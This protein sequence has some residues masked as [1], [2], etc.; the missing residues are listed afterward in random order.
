[1]SLEGAS[2]LLRDTVWTTLVLSA[3]ILV[4]ALATGLLVSLSPYP[5][6][7]NTSMAWK[8]SKTSL[9][10]GAAPEVRY[11]ISDPKRELRNLRKTKRS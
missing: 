6:K 2:D 3:P 7:I 1:M 4:T 9:L 5:S 10:I 8:N 11:L